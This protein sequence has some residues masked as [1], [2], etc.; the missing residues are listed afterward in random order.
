MNKN[1]WSS[2]LEE[3]KVEFKKNGILSDV[4]KKNLDKKK[5]TAIEKGFITSSDMNEIA[6]MSINVKEGNSNTKKEVQ[7]NFAKRGGPH[8]LI[9]GEKAKD[10][11]GTISRLLTYFKSEVKIVIFLFV[12][13]VVMVLCQVL[14]P[15]LQSS[16]IDYIDKRVFSEVPKVLLVM[17]IMF[18]VLSL[19]NLIQ[20]LL[21]AKLSQ[22]IVLKMR[23]DL[24]K[25][26]INLP[27]SYF[28]N[29]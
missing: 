13:I 18:L 17:I 12:T 10:S 29:N 23:N 9:G 5:K 25:K 4:S 15:R 11:K 19:F 6:K 7:M 8:G 14:T 16:A 26:I 22:N 1:E 20:G 27:I 2:F 21:S 24:F 28:D 3:L